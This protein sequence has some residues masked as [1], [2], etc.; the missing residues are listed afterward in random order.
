MPCCVYR[1][2]ISRYRCA[3]WLLTHRHCSIWDICPSTDPSLLGADLWFELVSSMAEEWAECGPYMDAHGCD[4]LGMAYPADNTT[5]FY[6]PSELPPNGTETLF[7]T[8]IVT[9]PVS[10]ATYSYTYGNV[11]HV[12]TVSS[13]DA[14][15]TGGSSS[16]SGGDDGDGGSGGEGSGSSG[17]SSDSDEE[18]GAAG[19]V[20]PGVAMVWLSMF[21]LGFVMLM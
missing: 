13:A 17:G 11:Q 9:S 2:S 3:P 20:G 1:T 7:N 19:V 15:P 6:K 10:G 16:G 18:D 5:N 14:R 21:G 12:V 4:D 8:G